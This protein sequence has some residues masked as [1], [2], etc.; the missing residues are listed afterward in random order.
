[1][2]TTTREP[3]A[4]STFQKDVRCFDSKELI[5]EAL[6]YMSDHEFSQIVVRRNG[7]IELLSTEGIVKWLTAVLVA[8][9]ERIHSRPIGE[10]VPFEKIK[11]FTIIKSNAPVTEVRAAFRVDQDRPRL[12]AVI[13]TDDGT[14]RGRPIGFVTPWDMLLQYSD[15]FRDIE[16]Q[17]RSFFLSP[18][19][20][21]VVRLLYRAYE[22]G[23]P[24]LSDSFICKELHTP[25]SRLR[26]TFRKSK[27]WGTL[28][29]NGSRPGMLNL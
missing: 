6:R 9:K 27:A 28:I 10:V 19:Q 15:D 22:H 18:R 1:M 4:I 3:Q 11:T 16:W 25:S 24:Q 29:V 2:N 14:A 7:K 8:R 13:I 5:K 26:D 17:G 21:D 23:T 20:A 12:A